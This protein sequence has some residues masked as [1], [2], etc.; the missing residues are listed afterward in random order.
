MSK[1]KEDNQY[2]IFLLDK[3]TFGLPI[4][5]IKEIIEHTEI[6]RVPMMPKFIPGVINL[7]GNVVP[8]VDVNYRFFGKVTNINRKTCIIIFESNVEET[9]IEVGVLVDI[10][11]EVVDIPEIEP[12]PS[13]GSTL[14]VE[15]VEGIGKLDEKFVIILNIDRVLDITELNEWT[16]DKT[17]IENNSEALQ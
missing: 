4:L 5:K 17:I 1:T 11:N 7:R 14:R 13:F 10:V 6:T 9:K 2:L 16:D 12:A 8:V 15:F 3:E